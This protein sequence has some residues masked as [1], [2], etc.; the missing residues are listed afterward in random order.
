MKLKSQIKFKKKYV[1]NILRS[2]LPLQQT[3]QLSKEQEY[4]LLQTQCFLADSSSP[5]V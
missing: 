5:A 2:V 4:H 1:C 3:C